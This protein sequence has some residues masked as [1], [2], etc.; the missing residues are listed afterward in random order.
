MRNFKSHAD[1]AIEFGSGIN[2]ILGENGAGK[3]SVLEA[4]SFALF[5]NYSGNLEKLVRSGSREMSVDVTFTS[6]GKVYKVSR[7][8]TKSATD[9]R[10]VVI[11]G[12][13]KELRS[14]DAGVDE[15]I[16]NILRMD[17]YVFSNAIYVRQGEIEKLLTETSH[18]KK[19]LIGRL[20]GI[21]SLEKVWEMMKPL[22]DTYATRKSVTEG[23]I[24]RE[25]DIRKELDS[26]DG[27]SAEAKERLSK[28]TSNISKISAGLKDAESEEKVL[29]ENEKKY[30]EASVKADEAR[31]ALER[32][33]VR[34]DDAVRKLSEADESAK[35]LAEISGRLKTCRRAEIEK[36]ME[37]C[38]KKI[39]AIDEKTGF[40]RGRISDMAEYDG[41]LES[42]AASCPLCGSVLT[43]DHRK[44][45]VKERR[46]KIAAMQDEVKALV[47]ERAA[48]S[49]EIAK[50]GA[51]LDEIVKLERRAAELNIV[52]GGRAEL[53][54]A[55]D[56]GRKAT[57]ELKR[58][59]ASLEKVMKTFESGRKAHADVKERVKLLRDEL[60]GLNVARGNLEGTLQ[61]LERSL[62][63]L[64]KEESS[65]KAKKKEHGNLT[66]FISI[67]NE[68][69]RVFDKSG[70]QLELRKRAVPMIENHMREFFREFNFEYSDIS[71][72]GDYDVTLYGPGGES[73][74]EMMSGGERIAVALAL[75]LGI[76]RTLAGSSAETVMLDEPTIFLDEQRRLDLIEVLNKMT[77]IPQMIVV[78]HDSA[79]EDAADRITVVKKKKGVSS[80]E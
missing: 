2:V 29:A 61:Q 48:L 22:I 64:K 52:A 17:R 35:M 38:R 67:L 63:T 20:L 74:T 72:D 26:V 62:E 32:E 43:E 54:S 56:K 34:M 9:S 30:F 45:M 19:Q 47:G 39:S 40:L 51:N 75:R 78:T 55:V 60:G 66:D 73:S 42:A 49:S 31:S 69:R 12:S 44:N 18:K 57:G 70:L 25:A 76:A 23:E 65:L 77:V 33:N 37:S 50:N 80:C 36:I 15:E 24:M 14:G 13:E 27:Q 59:L 7:R 16:G 68:I 10:L 28:I 6:H 79:M 8:R 71:L 1:T 53:A 41:K 3:T 4:I 58:N 21:E 11:D 5:K 46:D